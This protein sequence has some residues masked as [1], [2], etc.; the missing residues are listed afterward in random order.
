M[1]DNIVELPDPDS[2]SDDDLRTKLWEVLS[3]LAE[4]RIY[5]EDTDRLSDRELYAKLY[6]DILRIEAPA[7]DDNARS[8]LNAIW[9]YVRSYTVSP[10]S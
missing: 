3:R 6:H 9:R 8:L 10:K 5:L 1:P 7:I 2:I 4:R